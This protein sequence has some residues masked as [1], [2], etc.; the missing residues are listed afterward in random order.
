MAQGN[1]SFIT[2]K[3][4]KLLKNDV[5]AGTDVKICRDYSPISK[6]VAASE[7]MK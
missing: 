2:A 6:S 7:A 3:K 4:H 1:S 5:V